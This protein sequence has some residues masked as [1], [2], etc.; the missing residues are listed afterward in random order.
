VARPSNHDAEAVAVVLAV[1]APQRWR[2]TDALN[3][4]VKTDSKAVMHGL[5]T[6]DSAR[7]DRA[8]DRSSVRAAAA[9]ILAVQQQRHRFAQLEHVRAHQNPS[10]STDAFWNDRADRAARQA[11][12]SLDHDNTLNRC[13]LRITDGP[14]VIS[15]AAEH[16]AGGERHL[17]GDVR[18]FVLA[19][20]QRGYV[21]ALLARTSSQADVIDACGAATVRALGRAVG[22]DAAQAVQVHALRLVSC[23]LPTFVELLRD[24]AGVA[25][26]TARRQVWLRRRWHRR[27]YRAARAMAR[28]ADADGDQ[29]MVPTCRLCNTG[30]AE[31]VAHFVTCGGALAAERSRQGRAAVA[32]VLRGLEGVADADGAAAAAWRRLTAADVHWAESVGCFRVSRIARGIRDAQSAASNVRLK[33]R[34]V[35][36]LRRGLL[37]VSERMWR[38]RDEQLCMLAVG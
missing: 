4:H 16:P 8:R 32:S 20:Q 25:T 15:T 9:A 12:A 38:R 1:T 10:T 13:D 23:T 29:A 11:A 27:E 26:L 34:H 17:V 31:T 37:C 19:E 5:A 7:L 22:P 33:N 18:A 35:K 28:Q 24:H 30:E 21:S 3:I 6:Y 36:A 2:P 14:V